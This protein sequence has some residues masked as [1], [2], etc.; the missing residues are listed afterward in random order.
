M[1]LPL[2]PL[3]WFSAF[4]LLPFPPQARVALFSASPP[5]SLSSRF[6]PSRPSPRTSPGLLTRVVQYPWTWGFVPCPCRLLSLRW[7]LVTSSL[8]LLAGLVYPLASEPASLLAARRG[9][10]HREC[11]RHRVLVLGPCPEGSWLFSAR[12]VPLLPAV[13]W[14]F[15][16]PGAARS[17][18]S[19]P[20]RLGLIGP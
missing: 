15:V 17:S 7:P 13:W 11:C 20:N 16:A 3:L 14:L 10:C 12:A 8:V 6:A 2:L 9:Y 18:S 19:C 1:R 4:P 5:V